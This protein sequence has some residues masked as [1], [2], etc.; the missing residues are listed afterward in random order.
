MVL[1]AGLASEPVRNAAPQV[2][3]RATAQSIRTRTGGV[4]DAVPLLL[5]YA[6][7]HPWPDLHRLGLA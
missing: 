5:G 3:E 6:S 2:G 4:L 1:A 7:M